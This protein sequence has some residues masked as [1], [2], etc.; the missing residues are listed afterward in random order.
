MASSAGSVGV[1][2]ESAYY[3]RREQM[4]K[5]AAKFESGESTIDV[6]GRLVPVVGGDG[7]HEGSHSNGEE[8]RER[9]DRD[10]NRLATAVDRIDAAGGP[11]IGDSDRDVEFI[12][13]IPTNGTRDRVYRYAVRGPGEPAP[14][15]VGPAAAAAWRLSLRRICFAVLAVVFAFVCIMLQTLPLLNASF[16]PEHLIFDGILHELMVVRDIS[17]HIHNCDSLD[18][19]S[20]SHSLSGSSESSSLSLLRPFWPFGFLENRFDCGDAVLHIPSVEILSDRYSATNSRSVR[21]QQKLRQIGDQIGDLAETV[22]N[23]ATKQD[24][25]ARRSMLLHGPYKNG[26]DVEW[27]TPCVSQGYDAGRQSPGVEQTCFRGVH[28]KIITQKEVDSALKMAADIISRGGDHLQIRRDTTKLEYSIPVS[29]HLSSNTSLPLSLIFCR[30]MFLTV[31]L[32]HTSSF[33]THII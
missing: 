22:R 12:P 8:R 4:R 21:V 7:P 32:K 27:P 10:E 19:T 17:D 2:G 23:T 11:N 16:N 6:D 30:I 1:G 25:S 13:I 9:I 20:P 29:N 26:V 18:R 31:E 5:L 33:K 28:D 15:V 24:A 14:A 3:R